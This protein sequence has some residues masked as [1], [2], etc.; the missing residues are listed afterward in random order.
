MMTIVTGFVHA[1]CCL[2]VCKQGHNGFWDIIGFC[3]TTK[4]VKKT[5]EDEGAVF[6]GQLDAKE[7]ASFT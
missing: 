2:L 6:C 3:V 5:I 1:C 4:S 7:D